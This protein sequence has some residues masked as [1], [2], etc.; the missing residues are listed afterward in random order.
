MNPYRELKEIVRNRELDPEGFVHAV[1]AT[2]YST[3]CDC[4]ADYL[5]SEKFLKAFDRMAV[6]LA[7]CRRISREHGM[8]PFHAVQRK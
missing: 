4:C 8:E 2:V 7:L 5:R 3:C 1:M 6:E